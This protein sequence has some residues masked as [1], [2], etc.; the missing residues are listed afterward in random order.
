MPTKIST[1]CTALCLAAAVTASAAE[2]PEASASAPATAKASLPRLSIKWECKQDCTPNDKVPP[3]IEQAYRHAAERNG[4]TVSDSEV[5]EVSIVD[6]R[7]RPPGVR[8]AFGLF[9]GKDRLGVRI[10]YRG[11]E[12][13]AEDTSANTIQGM[14]SLSEAVGKRSYEQIAAIARSNPA[15]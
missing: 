3:L 2:A 8:V 10:H 1:L 9:A 6:Y 12:A 15:H 7:Q 4:Y 5:A 11:K 13:S 14:N